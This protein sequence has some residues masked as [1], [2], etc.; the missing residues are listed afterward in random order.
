MNTNLIYLLY[1]IQNGITAG[2]KT[3]TIKNK[4]SKSNLC[5]KVLTCL[6]K[7]G[8]IKSFQYTLNKKNIIEF[9]I[10]LRYL[11]NNKNTIKNITLISKPGKRNYCS[12]QTL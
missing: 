7:E 11:T 8:F 5:F 10:N 12:I 6:K 3:V 4:I 9:E 1:T 2:L